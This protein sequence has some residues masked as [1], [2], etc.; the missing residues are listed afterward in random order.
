MRLGRGF[1]IMGAPDPL[2][3]KVFPRVLPGRVAWLANGAGEGIAAT[4]AGYEKNAAECLPCRRAVGGGGR[5]AARADR[6]A[7]EREDAC[8]ASV[9]QGYRLPARAYGGRHPLARAGRGD[10]PGR[11]GP[12]ARPD[13]GAGRLRARKG[14]PRRPAHGLLH[15]RLLRRAGLSERARPLREGAAAEHHQ[16]PGPG[17]GADGRRRGP[18]R[19]DGLCVPALRGEV[20]PREDHPPLCE[21]ARGVCL[22]EGRCGLLQTGLAGGRLGAHARRRPGQPVDVRR[23]RPRRAVRGEGRFPAGGALLQRP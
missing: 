20:E 11:H 5:G 9:H 2:A 6:V 8:A 14:F 19:R 16:G 13:E 1:G 23:A 3:C 7:G 18:A 21:A 4:S 12:D 10:G 15:P 22:R 17:A